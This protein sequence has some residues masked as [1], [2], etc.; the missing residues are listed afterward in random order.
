M[1]IERI[2]EEGAEGAE[3]NKM[4]EEEGGGGRE[5]GDCGQKAAPKELLRL[6]SIVFRQAHHCACVF[7]KPLNGHI[8]NKPLNC[9]FNSRAIENNTCR[10]YY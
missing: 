7:N 5:G 4:E 10:L 2:N 1:R 8:F 6:R 9:P 3:K